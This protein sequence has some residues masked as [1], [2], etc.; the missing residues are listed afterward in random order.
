MEHRRWPLLLRDGQ[1]H[2]AVPAGAFQVQIQD[3]DK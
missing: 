1:G 3:P 2:C